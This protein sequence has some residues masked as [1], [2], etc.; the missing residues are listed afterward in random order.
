MLGKGWSIKSNANGTDPLLLSNVPVPFLNRHLPQTL[1]TLD[2][3]VTSSL[4]HLI[5]PTASVS[6]LSALDALSALKRLLF[7]DLEW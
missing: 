4:V 3:I 2:N 1:E 7:I 5:T 6:R